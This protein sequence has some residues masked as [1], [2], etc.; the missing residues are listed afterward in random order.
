MFQLHELD[1]F[2]LHAYENSILYKERTKIWHDRK[3][4]IR[5]EFNKGEKVLLFHSK[6]KFKQPKLKSRW[7]GPYVVKHQYP[8]GFEELCG[9]SEN[10]FIV[11][12]TNSN[13]FTKKKVSMIEGRNLLLSFPKT[14]KQCSCESSLRLL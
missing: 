8:S 10:T 5:K 11:M 2:R 12:V 4:K 6:Y 13:Y 14:K 1:E 3:L 9:K 7:L